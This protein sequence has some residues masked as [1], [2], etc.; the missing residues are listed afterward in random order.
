MSAEQMG[1]NAFQIS[2]LWGRSWELMLSSLF[3]EKKY[4]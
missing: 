2:V 4:I 3:S 1:E